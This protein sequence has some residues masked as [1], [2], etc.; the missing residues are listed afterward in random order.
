MYTNYASSVLNVTKSLIYTVNSMKLKFRKHL[1]KESIANS[2]EWPKH[3]TGELESFNLIFVRTASIYALL[4]IIIY[5]HM[6]M[7]KHVP[8]S[9][10]SRFLI[11]GFSA[12]NHYLI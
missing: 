1:F 6:Y 8:H 5:I 3:I 10:G 12:K 4:Y 2:S 11:G 7:R 9:A